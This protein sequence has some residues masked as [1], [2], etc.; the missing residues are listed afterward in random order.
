MDLSGCSLDL[1]YYHNLNYNFNLQYT[2]DTILFHHFSKKILS[3]NDMH[4]L[5]LGQVL[6][7]VIIDAF[8]EIPIELSLVTN[9]DLLLKLNLHVFLKLCN[10]VSLYP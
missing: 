2:S 6:F 4:C 8:T 7:T 9:L 10:E 5:D 1:K 3:P